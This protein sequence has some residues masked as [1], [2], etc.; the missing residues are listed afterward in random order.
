M[1]DGLQV[2]GSHHVQ[3]L[4]MNGYDTFISTG[5][6]TI[7]TDGWITGVHEDAGANFSLKTVFLPSMIDATES[8]GTFADY[9]WA[10]DADEQNVCYHGGDWGSGSRAGLFYLNL[11]NV[12]SNLCASIGGR[13]AKK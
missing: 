9:F 10:S 7:S 8:N 11:N 2:D 1:V 6:T 12:A 4:D 5:V 13:L 3:I